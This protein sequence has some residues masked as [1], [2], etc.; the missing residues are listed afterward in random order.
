MA[1]DTGSDSGYDSSGVT[2]S[3]HGGEAESL[4]PRLSVPTDETRAAMRNEE[5][6]E[7]ALD[8]IMVCDG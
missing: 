4:A 3:K 5:R 1:A 6:S 2:D 7:V 8:V